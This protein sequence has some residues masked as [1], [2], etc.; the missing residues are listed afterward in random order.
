VKTAFDKLSSSE[1]Q[2]A[3]YYDPNAFSVVYY[4]LGLPEAEKLLRA[5]FWEGVHGYSRQ[6]LANVWKELV[7]SANFSAHYEPYL[8]APGVYEPGNFFKFPGMPR[9]AAPPRVFKAVDWSIA[10]PKDLA[11]LATQIWFPGARLFSWLA[12]MKLIPTSFLW[13]VMLAG[14]PL[15]PIFRARH[16]GLRP[17]QTILILTA[18]ALFGEMSF[19]AVLFIFRNKELILCQPLI[20]LMM[21]LSVSLWVERA[22]SSRSRPSHQQFA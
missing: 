5:V 11:A 8:P 16:R 22:A 17:A 18:V 10:Q 2:R 19:S 3:N 1:S 14:F 4:Y 12:F 20:Y 15:L 9:P 6:Y 13:I 21:G 7:H